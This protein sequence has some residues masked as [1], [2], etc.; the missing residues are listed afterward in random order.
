MLSEPVFWCVI[1]EFYNSSFI[2][3]LADFNDIVIFEYFLLDLF[4]V[5]TQRVGDLALHN[6]VHG[7]LLV[8]DMV[9]QRVV[10]RNGCEWY[11][12]VI[13]GRAPQGESLACKIE[14][15]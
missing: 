12:Q 4:A 9:Q 1:G 10:T 14:G 3:G 8:G 13:V 15:C 2:A 5:T 6:F 7:F 11:M